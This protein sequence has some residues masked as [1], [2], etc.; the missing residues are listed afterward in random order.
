MIYNHLIFQELK[1]S[2][3]NLK[4]KETEI[5][6]L[7]AFETDRNLLF[8]ENNAVKET[9]SRLKT[10]YSKLKN[11]YN[12]IVDDL[13]SLRVKYNRFKVEHAKIDANYKRVQ[14]QKTEADRELQDF[15]E[16]YLVL[17]ELKEKICKCD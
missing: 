11:D 3:R 2:N 8:E 17:Q 13:R 9:N 6:Q 14:A 5:K 4:E 10:S 16:K 15:N 12:E 7:K 1:V